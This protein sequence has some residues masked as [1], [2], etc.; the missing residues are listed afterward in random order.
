MSRR[1]WISLGGWCG[2]SQ[3]LAKRGLTNSQTQL[4]FDLVRCTLDGIAEFTKIGFG[5]NGCNYFPPLH[6]SNSSCT[7]FFKPDPVSIWLLFRGWHTAFTHYDL[8]REE[9]KQVLMQ[10]MDAWSSLF[11]QAKYQQQQQVPIT[12]LRTSISEDPLAEMKFIPQL[13]KVFDEAS[14]GKLD[15]RIVLVH[16]INNN[17]N[18]NSN[19]D[20]T[21]EANP[22]T[23]VT[24][25][26]C[27]INDRAVVWQLVHE[28]PSNEDNVSLFDKS[29]SGYNKI[30]DF[31]IN[32]NDTIATTA[33]QN[34]DT[35]LIMDHSSIHIKNL[36]KS[37]LLSRVEGIPTF[38]GT[39]TGFG[40]TQSAALNGICLS[41][42]D[43]TGHKMIQR[44]LFDTKHPWTP[45]ED[46][47]LIE[48][49]VILQNPDVGGF[50]DI[51]ALVEKTANELGRGSNEV[52]ERFKEFGLVTDL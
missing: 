46:E 51:V 2:P 21:T 28:H 3:V 13:Q 15:Y 14:D 47:K 6:Q 24:E 16:H 43:R 40:S 27:K 26:I 7:Q 33:Y 32:N 17:N 4:P 5:R 22:Q 8:N 45:E 48:T 10:R 42:G 18:S 30:I 50:L 23:L 11:E 44:D 38:L 1:R 52:L 9:N 19:A 41:C 39:C 37:Q 34:V 49:L 36:K 25:P 12:F 31:E 20:V 29:E 35:K